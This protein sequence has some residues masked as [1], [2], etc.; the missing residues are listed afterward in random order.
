MYGKHSENGYTEVIDGIRIKTLCFGES[1][2]MAE[3]LLQ[4]DAILPEH[5]HPNEQTSY[6][7]KGKI[8]L[9]VGNTVREL[10]Q[11]DSW[12]I[13]KEMRHRAE[14]LEDSVA[15]EVF[16]PVREDYLKFANDPDVVK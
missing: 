2:L 14:I 1:M 16:S 4:K 6:L 5:S 3:F 9:F 10:A 7:I 13:A 8:R 15:I 11:G 12:N